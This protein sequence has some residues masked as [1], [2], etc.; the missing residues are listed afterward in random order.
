M[1]SGIFGLLILASFCLMGLAASTE[2]A[3]TIENQIVELLEI[4]R[5]KSVAMLT[6]P[7]STDGDMRPLFDRI[8]EKSAEYNITFKCFFAPEHGLRGDR[9]D[10]K[11]DEDYIDEETGVRVYS[12]YGQR[13]AP[14]TQQLIGVDLFIYDIQ[15]VGA[16]YYTYMWTL[17]YTIEVLATK[18]IM[19]V[20]FDRPNPLGRK[21]EGCPLTYDTGL[22][23]RLLP[24][25]SYSLP[26]RYGLTVG[27][28]VSY[29]GRFLPKFSY[30]LVSMGSKI[31][32]IKDE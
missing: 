18:G 7:T 17:T 31:Y 21:I 6:N 19:L 16:R 3:V 13:K 2:R 15:D 22:V 29:V 23:G 26:I 9:Q 1:K 24:G 5:G 4:C 30:K 28:F 11:G 10:G 27:E 25:Q 8:I 32:E 12:L 14:T 20:V